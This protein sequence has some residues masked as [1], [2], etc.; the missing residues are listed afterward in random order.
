MAT[1]AGVI[2]GIA[3][4]YATALY[5][6]ADE[7]KVLDDVASDLRMLQT[8]I[9]ESKDLAQLVRSPLIRRDAQAAAVNAVMAKAGTHDL[10]RRFIGVVCGNG[11]L[12][13][14]PAVITAFLAELARRRGEVAAEVVSARPLDE[15][16]KATV[17]DALRGFAGGKVAVDVKVDPSLIGGLVVR[18]GSRMVDSSVRSKLQRLQLAMKGA[19]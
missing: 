7:A 12:I 17:A 11:R 13:V 19:Q 4:R 2:G 3:G 1:G 9:A 18:V 14:L 10:T 5:D 8:L 16:Q 15:Q 6:L